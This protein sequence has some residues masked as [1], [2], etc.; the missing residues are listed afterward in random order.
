M[1]SFYISETGQLLDVAKRAALDAVAGYTNVTP[2][3]IGIAVQAAVDVLQAGK[4]FGLSSVED[5]D[6]LETVVRPASI[7]VGSVEVTPRVRALESVARAAA[8]IHGPHA[9]DADCVLCSALVQL[10]DLDAAS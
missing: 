6:Q 7:D 8:A 3:T 1:A 10:D 9:V 5:A 4:R 2:Y